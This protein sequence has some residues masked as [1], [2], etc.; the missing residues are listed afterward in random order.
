[1]TIGARILTYRKKAGLTQSALAELLGVTDKAVSKWE[2]DISCPDITLLPSL[3]KALSVSADALL[4]KDGECANEPSEEF[5]S[6]EKYL[7]GYYGY[8]VPDLHPEG[9]EIVLIMDYP[10]EDDAKH[11]YALSARLGEEVN[12]YLFGSNAPFTASRLKSGR[13][14]VTYVSNVPLANLEKPIDKLVDELEYTRL[15]KFHLNLFLLQGFME[16]MKKLILSDT[17]RVI[18]LTREFNQ[19]YFGAFISHA[20]PDIFTLFW[21]KASKGS[22]K[23]L[24]VGP[25]LFWNSE[26]Y[27]KPVGLTELKKY[28]DSH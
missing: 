25:P 12:R 1:M 4:G 20:S 23:I 26:R 11:G 10:F 5:I 24:Y 16:K 13:L 19:K 17:V 14:G 2:R 28:I 7:M 15:N 27:K 22:L 3:A 9:E 21:E 6:L 8:V 18:A